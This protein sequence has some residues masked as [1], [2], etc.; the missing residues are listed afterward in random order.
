MLKY[1]LDYF[2]WWFVVP[3]SV[4]PKQKLSK[5]ARAQGAT[6]MNIGDKVIAV[7]SGRKTKEL[8]GGDLSRRGDR[9]PGFAGLVEE[10][11]VMTVKVCE[12][13]SIFST[14]MT[15]IS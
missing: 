4:R 13:R 1:L 14:K 15:C 11:V 7:G 12:R 5:S 9:T 8:N 2:K 3:D 10:M 6:N